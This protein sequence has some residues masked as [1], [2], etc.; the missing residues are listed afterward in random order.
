MTIMGLSFILFLF[1]V[2]KV[3]IFNQDSMIEKT[4]I[5]KDA[6]FTISTMPF[7]TEQIVYYVTAPNPTFGDD[8]DL[9]EKLSIQYVKQK[10]FDSLPIA[11]QVYYADGNTRKMVA[12]I[13]LNRF[14]VPYLESLY[15]ENILTEK[16]YE[17]LRIHKYNHP[18]TIV[19]LRREVAKK[20]NP[21]KMALQCK[22]S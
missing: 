12:E 10:D 9:F 14:A 20:L 18:S 4:L 11:I 7:R 16:Q 22:Q 3:K 21:A 2:Y 1:F 19:Q 15:G 8:S 17:N 6:P 13:L 5:P